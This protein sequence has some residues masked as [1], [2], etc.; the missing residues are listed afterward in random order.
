[1]PS[2][3]I[4]DDEKQICE[5]FSDLFCNEGYRVHIAL[6]GDQGIRIARAHH[7]DIILSDIRMPGING[8]EA[9]KAFR[10]IPGLAATPIILITGNADL[11]DMRIGMAAGAD[12]YLAKPIK[13]TELIDTVRRHLER[14]RTRRDAAREEL[15]AERRHTGTL[16]PGNLVDPL[17]EIIGCASVLEGDA[18]I[19]SPTHIA[20]FA[21]DII[22]GAETL[23]QRFENFLIYSRLRGG[24]LSPTPPAL[25]AIHELLTGAARQIARRHHRLETL[26]F[27]V[28]EVSAGISSDLLVKAVSEVIDN[29]CR[30]S[31]SGEPI[32]ISLTADDSNFTIK[33]AD[34]G[35]G[36]SEC[37][38]AALASDNQSDGYGLRLSRELTALLGGEWTLDNQP[39]RGCTVSFKF[40]IT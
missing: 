19:M 39:K 38:V 16:L 29:A 37:Q 35:M 26:R 20:E 23:N 9:V 21:R 40:P 17:H 14:S 4:I 25:T 27:D 8:H 22:N 1:M 30:Y 7:P 33:I 34:F 13:L 12:D 15:I 31:L 10:Q 3:L 36:L 32:D 24:S 6:D 11:E 2:I 18:N 28:A 5:T